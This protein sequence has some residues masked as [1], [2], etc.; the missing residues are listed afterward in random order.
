MSRQFSYSWALLI[1]AAIVAIGCHPTQP[2]YFFDDGDLSHYLDVATDIEYPDVAEE[3]ID[4]V[5]GAEAPLTLENASARTDW[6]LSLEEVIRITLTNSKVLRDLGGRIASTAPDTISRNVMSTQLKTVY[7]PGLV[8]SGVGGVVGSQLS[9]NGVEAALS[10]FDARLRSN[11]FWQYNDRPQNSNIP[12]VNVRQ[13]RQQLSRF[14]AEI[15]KTAASGA[16]FAFRNNTI[17]DANN[18]I[19]RALPSDWNTNFEAEF[20]QPLLQGAGVQYNRIAGPIRFDTFNANGVAVFDG[21][22]IAR[23]RVD[24]T[25]ADF[26]AGV[27]DVVQSAEEAYWE[28]YFSYHNLNARKAGLK[29]AQATWKKVH[30]LAVYS[31][32]GGDT[33]KEAQARSQYYSFRAQVETAL[34]ELYRR[35]AQLRYI[36]G[37]AVSDGRVIRPSDDPTT[38]EITFDWSEIHP[39][40]LARRVEIRKQKWEI[41]K[42]GLELIAARNHLL[43]RLDA[44]GRY[45]WLGLGDRLIANQGTGLGPLDPG[46]NAFESLTDGDFQE[47]EIGLQLSVPIG[48]R[49]AMSRVR[50]HEMLI[51]RDRALLEDL[52]LEISHQLGDALRDV[53]NFYKTSESNFNGLVATEK[54]V[55]AVVAAYETNAVTLDLVL[56]AQRRRADAE[57]AYYRSLIDYN[58][59]IARVHNRKGSLLEYTSVYLS[60]GPWPG[61][62]YFDAL[63]EARRRDASVAINYGFTRPKVISRGPYMQRGSGFVADGEALVPTEATLEQIERPPAERPTDVDQ[64]PA[65]TENRAGSETV[66]A[67]SQTASTLRTAAGPRLQPAVT[68]GGDDRPT[69]RAIRTRVGPPA[70]KTATSQTG[71][72]TKAETKTAAAKTGDPWQPRAVRSDSPPRQRPTPADAAP[73]QWRGTGRSSVRRAASATPV[74]KQ[75]A[76]RWQRAVRS[77]PG[78]GVRR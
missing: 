74:A 26:E 28:L 43:P 9:G 71:G 49:R 54:E 75:T 29:S 65:P 36:M 6:D 56:D 17:Y 69:D 63:R 38:A 46:S 70:S 48:N 20:S 55:N 73:L 41:K 60:E 12:Q 34:T 44:T 2:T 51:A 61:K 64:L 45:R 37:L 72:Q 62:A 30:A 7:D 59:A 5:T 21:V 52:E 24:L 76:G 35:E 67:P 77:Y 27:R 23:T 50:H 58:R 40:A 32:S 39:E 3:P 78:A 18:N 31:S 14:S 11:L 19:N 53:T 10:E 13:F 33:Q 8:E 22:L 57:T 4:E 66:S 42:R 68:S 47:W 16:T 15:S 1:L 25:L